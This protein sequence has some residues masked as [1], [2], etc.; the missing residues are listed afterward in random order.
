[1]M[2]RFRESREKKMLVT[3]REDYPDP[4]KRCISATVIHQIV[5]L[6]QCGMILESGNSGCAPWWSM[7]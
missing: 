1:M 3:A 4:G 2:E 6:F 7:C 5:F